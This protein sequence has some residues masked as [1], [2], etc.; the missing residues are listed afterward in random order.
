MKKVLALALALSVASS[1]VFSYTVDTLHEVEMVSAAAKTANVMV[2]AVLPQVDPTLAQIGSL[3]EV[4]NTL[5][6]YALQDQSSVMHITRVVE[7]LAKDA[8]WQDADQI[9]MAFVKKFGVVLSQAVSMEVARYLAGLGLSQTVGKMTDDRI[10]N[11]AADA[12]T[13][14]LTSAVVKTTFARIQHMVLAAEGAAAPSCSKEFLTSFFTSLASEVAYNIAGE[15][16]RQGAAG[17]RV[18]YIANLKELIGL[19][20]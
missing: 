6:A 16:I 9:D 18:D 11:R 7:A 20:N 10:V 17:S 1:Q 3:A 13:M 2:A 8:R 15:M 5:T 19:S 4:T 12:L 14:S